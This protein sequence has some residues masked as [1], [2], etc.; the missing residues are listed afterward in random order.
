MA[1]PPPM[2]SDLVGEATQ[3]DDPVP[4]YDALILLLGGVAGTATG[5]A[6]YDRATTMTGLAN[7]ARRSPTLVAFCPSDDNTYIYVGHSLSVYPSDPL[8]P[9]GFDGNI[10]TLVGN[11][12]ASCQPVALPATAFSRTDVRA[13][14]IAEIRGAAGFGGSPAVL[15]QGPHTATTADTEGLSVRPVMLMHKSLVSTTTS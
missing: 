4:D 1:A 15:R 10:I 12:P 13:K 6:V 3:W 14:T 7:L 5:A 8:N 9:L 2:F 11:D